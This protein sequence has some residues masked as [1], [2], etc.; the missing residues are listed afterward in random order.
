MDDQNIPSDPV[1]EVETPATAPEP[2][3]I[4]IE[5]ESSQPNGSTTTDLPSEAPESPI[6]APDPITVKSQN[7]GVNQ[8]ES[9]VP[10]PSNETSVTEPI[11]PVPEQSISQSTSETSIQLQ[12]ASAS[13]TLQSQPPVQ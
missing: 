10:E 12:P 4:P 7:G 1:V 8:P 5:P 11:Q 13:P 6:S 3:P 2:T 9:D